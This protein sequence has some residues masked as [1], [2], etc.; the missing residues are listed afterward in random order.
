MKTRY[1]SV[2]R[3]DPVNSAGEEWLISQQQQQLVDDLKADPPSTFW[4]FCEPVNRL[5]ILH[6]YPEAAV[7]VSLDESFARHFT[8]EQS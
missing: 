2:P 5:N 6:L 8:E 3:K 1:K 4:L 7:L